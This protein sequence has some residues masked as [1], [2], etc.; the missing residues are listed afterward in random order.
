MLKNR[1]DEFIPFYK[2]DL[3][4]IKRYKQSLIKSHLTNLAGF[5]S[6]LLLR[7]FDKVN[8]K[9]T[10]AENWSRFMRDA[11]TNMIG[12]SNYRALNIHGIEKKDQG[13]YNRYIK[14]GLSTKG[15]MLTNAQREKIL[16]F[17]IAIR[18]NGAEKEQILFKKY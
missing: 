3:D 16:D 17:G 5:S 2:K 1:G 9:E 15:M 12:M 11:F 6:E 7:R 14:N 8:K 4:V 10:F 18:V 13:L